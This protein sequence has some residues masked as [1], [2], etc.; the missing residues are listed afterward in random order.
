MAKSHFQQTVV[1]VTQSCFVLK[2][3]RQFLPLQTDA[4]VTNCALM[5]CGSDLL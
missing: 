4:G 5:C 1:I 2:I 3:G